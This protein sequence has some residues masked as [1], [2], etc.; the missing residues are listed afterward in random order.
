MVEI[1]AISE[2]ID[3][4]ISIKYKKVTRVNVYEDESDPEKVTGTKKV[5]TWGMAQLKYDDGNVS[6]MTISECDGKDVDSFEI[7][8]GTDLIVSKTIPE[9]TM[10]IDAF[11]GDAETDT[12]T[13]AEFGALVLGKT[14]EEEISALFNGNIII[15]VS[16][17]NAEN[18]YET[19][20]F[21]RYGDVCYALTE[22]GGDSS[23][24]EAEAYWWIENG[25][26]YCG[27]YVDGNF[28]TT[29]IE[30]KKYNSL[31]EDSDIFTELFISDDSEQTLKTV[32]R[33]KMNWKTAPLCNASYIVKQTVRPGS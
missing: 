26:Y 25:R 16:S 11:L 9:P 10:N 21:E 14:T 12:L 3:G 27:A 23:L 2:T 30:E 6:Y 7:G 22:T 1:R 4:A 15:V 29:E 13:R 31:F 33:E 20:Y 28:V 18:E 8:F 19:A 5:T 32:V 17:V 24:D